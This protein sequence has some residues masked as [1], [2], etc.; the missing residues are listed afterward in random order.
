VTEWEVGIPSV[1]GFVASEE[2]ADRIDRLVTDSPV[3]YDG[4]AEAYF[5]LARGRA[6]P[7][8]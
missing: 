5:D 2:E 7:A 8:P 1:E 3:L 6:A 4:D